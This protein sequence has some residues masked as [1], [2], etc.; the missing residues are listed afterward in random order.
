MTFK[1]GDIPWNKG[2]YL[3]EETKK[4]I[5]EIIKEQFKNGRK[6]SMGMLGKLGKKSPRKGLSTEEAYGKE[7]ADK[8][9]KKISESM[10]K[11]W[12]TSEH[13]KKFKKAMQ[14]PEVIQKI[15]KGWFKKGHHPKTQITTEI[16]KK[17]WKNPKYRMKMKKM[18]K[19][20]WQD[21]KY[22]EKM[23]K[24]ISKGTK[25][26]WQDQKRRKKMSERSRKQ[27]QTEEYQRKIFKS[28]NIKPT[29]PEKFL[30]NFFK[31][32]DLPFKYTG[33]Y[34]FWIKGR[35]P[36]FINCDGQKQIIEFNGFY[37]HNKREEIER[38]KLFSEYGFTTLFL[39]YPDLENESDLLNKINDFMVVKK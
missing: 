23:S 27:W 36:D 12:Q 1:N 11:R 21:P 22:R 19:K 34:S 4:K 10:K 37:T 39:H 28:L 24:S 3:S 5:S 31:K 7:K 25:K 33:D 2:K 30:I 32:H 16:L 17:K 15:S 29:H 9:R 26:G 6:P 13:Q 8:I 14:R 35:N 38:S 20:I 18:S